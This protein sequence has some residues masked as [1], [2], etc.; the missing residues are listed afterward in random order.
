MEEAKYSIQRELKDKQR[1]LDSEKR[2]I[3]TKEAELDRLKDMMRQRDELLKVGTRAR[4]AGIGTHCLT[5]VYSFYV[6]TWLNQ[7]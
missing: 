7:Q 1:Q 3:K 2:T 5:F 4:L 6:I